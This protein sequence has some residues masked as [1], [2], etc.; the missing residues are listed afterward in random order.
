MATSR[1]AS[2]AAPWLT[3]VPGAHAGRPG[4]GLTRLDAVAVSPGQELRIYG[5]GYRTARCTNLQ[6]P[7]RP[8]TGLTVFVT[9]G[10]REQAL[11]TVS[12]REPGG[13]FDVTVRLPANLRAGPAT[14]K[15]SQPVERSLHIQVG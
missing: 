12:A 7:G 13:I 10:D 4:P 11:A 9:Q 6:P 2:C 3:T 14:V 1:S 15:T 5:Y 8:F